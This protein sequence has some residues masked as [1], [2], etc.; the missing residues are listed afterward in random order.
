MMAAVLNKGPKEQR[1]GQRAWGVC[2]V[3]PLAKQKQ[4]ERKKLLCYCLVFLLYTLSILFSASEEI[5]LSCY[6]ISSRSGIYFRA[7]VTAW[8]VAFVC[9]LSYVRMCH[10]PQPAKGHHEVHRKSNSS[11]E[12]RKCLWHSI[13]NKMPF[14]KAF[15][16]YQAE[17]IGIRMRNCAINTSN[18]LSTDDFP[19]V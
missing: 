6:S 19:C 9:R 5:T 16:G 10:L 2:H 17:W 15:V 7:K 12:G 4:K 11:D 14:S 18:R 3:W 1:G 13:R 8:N